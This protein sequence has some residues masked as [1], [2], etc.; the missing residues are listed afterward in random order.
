MFSW[1]GLVYRP[2][3][4]YNL[5][6]IYTNRAKRAGRIRRRGPPGPSR[7]MRGSYRRLFGRVNDLGEEDDRGVGE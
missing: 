3:P 1:E 4:L 7:A 2:I 6:F 5:F